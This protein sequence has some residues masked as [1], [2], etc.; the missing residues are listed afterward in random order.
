MLNSSTC[1]KIQRILREN[2][3]S[4]THPLTSGIFN[5]MKQ[6]KSDTLCLSPKGKTWGLFFFYLARFF[7][8]SL[9]LSLARQRT[10]LP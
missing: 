9:S 1:K 8:P 10:E 5:Y 2:R 3:V 4:K 7:S 6:Q